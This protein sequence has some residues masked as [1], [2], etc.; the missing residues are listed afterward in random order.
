[1]EKGP[2]LDKTYMI[3]DVAE[4]TGLSQKRI[5]EYEKEGLIRPERDPNTRNRRYTR[6]D[7]DQIIR[8]KTLLHAHGFT[9]SGLKHL[10]AFA[11]CWNIFDCPFRENCPAYLNP[12]QM[13]YDIGKKDP[14]DSG[15]RCRNCPVFLNRGVA[16]FQLLEKPP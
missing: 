11:P 14:G 16:L 13:C 9:L 15:T 8:V 5:R 12:R 1:M 2:D 10:L 4:E 6:F 3:R 7:I